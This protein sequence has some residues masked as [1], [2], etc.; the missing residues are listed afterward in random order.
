MA[1]FFEGLA[2]QFGKDLPGILSDHPTGGGEPLFVVGFESRE[3][4]GVATGALIHGR[5]ELQMDQVIAAREINHE[6][7]AV[8]APGEPRKK[9]FG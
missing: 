4:A 2:N 6:M 8:V 3:V 9:T 1:C 7:R 5:E